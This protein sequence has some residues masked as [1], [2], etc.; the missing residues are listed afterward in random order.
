MSRNED[1]VATVIA[2]LEVNENGIALDI[3][4]NHG[5]YSKLLASKFGKVYSFEP[6]PDNVT[7]IKAKVTEQNVQIEQKVIGTS[8]GVIDLFVCSANDGGHTIMEGLAKLKKWGHSVNNTIQVQSITLDTFCKDIKVDFIKCD[9]EGG[10]YEIFYHGQEILTRDYPTIVL[11]THQVSDI[12]SDQVK[13]DKLFKYFKDLG[14]SILDTKHNEVVAFTYD[15]HYLIQKYQKDG[16][17][18]EK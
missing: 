16:I 5:I 12:K 14:F 13:R 1:W 18:E 7:K 17:K 3:G 6:H 15:T 10:E 8:D 2:N 4:A 9:I 11:E